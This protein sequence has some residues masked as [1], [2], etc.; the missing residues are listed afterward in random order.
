MGKGFRKFFRGF[1]VLLFVYGLIS[2]GRFTF[3]SFQSATDANIIF[4]IFMV[5]LFTFL[6]LF[7]GLMILSPIFKAMAFADAENIIASV[8]V[9]SKTTKTSVTTGSGSTKHHIAFEFPDGTRKNFE[10]AVE[11]ANT[12][13][14]GESGTLTYR[15][16]GQHL[17]FVG[18]ERQTQQLN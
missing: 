16:S 6:S 3:H 10:I 2:V 12:I 17:F 1:L 14:E 18:F 5:G 7:F 15:E 9:I 13:L 4:S 11:V 8:K